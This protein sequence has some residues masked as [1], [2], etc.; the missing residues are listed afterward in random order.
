M[1]KS[2]EAVEFLCR[3]CGAEFLA[4]EVFIPAAEPASEK[5]TAIADNKCPQCGGVLDLRFPTTG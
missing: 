3:D 2:D 4:D 1:K 5:K